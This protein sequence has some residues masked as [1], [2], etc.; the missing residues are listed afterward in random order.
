MKTARL[1]KNLDKTIKMKQTFT[2]ESIELSNQGGIFIINENGHFVYSTQQIDGIP[3]LDRKEF[4]KPVDVLQLATSNH[5]TCKLNVDKVD[6]TLGYA[7]GYNA[8][9]NEFTR[10]QLVEAMKYA[11]SHLSSLKGIMCYI[12]QMGELSIPE[13]VTI[14]NNQVI[15]V[16]W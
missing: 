12:D 9:P 11:S 5:S 1:S 4:V 2:K 3:Q 10:E 7:A 8:N 13:S 14:E 6:Y 16:V 15:S